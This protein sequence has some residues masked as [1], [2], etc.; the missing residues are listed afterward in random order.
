[1]DVIGILFLWQTLI[2]CGSSLG[3]KVTVYSSFEQLE[4]RDLKIE[5]KI[6][7]RKEKINRYMRK[8]TRRNFGRKIKVI[9]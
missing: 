1:M 7:E 4:I 3:D 6:E 2:N 9:I 5:E 8:K